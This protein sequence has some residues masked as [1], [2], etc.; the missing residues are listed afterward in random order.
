MWMGFIAFGPLVHDGL[1]HDEDCAPSLVLHDESR[2]RITDSPFSP[3]KNEHCAVCHLFCGSRY[4]ESPSITVS[5]A[6]TISIARPVE[7]DT[8]LL[9]SVTGPLAARAP[10]AYS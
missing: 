6:L 2:H 3:N 8:F 5:T 4:I 9:A 10:P 7:Q 1:G